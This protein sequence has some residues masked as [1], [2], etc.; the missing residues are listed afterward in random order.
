VLVY[1]YG[2]RRSKIFITLQIIPAKKEKLILYH[3]T[4]KRLFLIL[5]VM[6][7]YV[8][9]H[10]QIAPNKYYVQFTDKNASPYSLE[11]PEAY[12]SQRALDRRA[13]FGIPVD[14]K[15]IPVNPQYLQAV[16]DAGASILNPT[17]WLN[18]VSI[19]TSDPAVISAIEALP[20]VENVMKSPVKLAGTSD[21][22]PFFRAESYSAMAPYAVHSM[23]DGAFYDYGPSLNQIQMIKGDQ[24]HELGY[25]G[26]GL[27]IAVLDAGFS[28]TDNLPVFDSLWDS[29]R[30]LGTR[31]FIDGGPLTFNKHYHG[32]M[33]LSCMGGN[34]PGQ[35]I[36]TAPEAS[37]WLFRTEDGGSE[38]IIEEYNWVTAAEFADSAGADIINSSLGYSTFDDPSQNHT[39]EDMDGNTTP[40][41]I[42]AD[43]AASR[44]MVVVSSAGNSGTSAWYYITAPADGDSVYTI[45]AVNHQGLPASFSSH[46]PTADGRIKPNVAAQ[47]EGTYFAS[48]DGSFIFGN[49]TSFSSPIIAGMMAC[50]W[51]ANPDMNNMEL[52]NAIQASGTLASNPDNKLGYGIPDFMIAHNILTVIDGYEQQA[53]GLITPFPNPFTGSFEVRVETEKPGTAKLTI[54]DISGRMMHESEYLLAS[55]ENQIMVSGLD[56]LKAGIYLLKFELGTVVKTAKVV[57]K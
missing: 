18:G 44:G 37:Y 38:Y 52:L 55:G 28:N 40:I 50:L 42:G 32:T 23:K 57:R 7:A 29:G 46:G 49:G 41:T 51:Q 39:Y 24:L 16:K 4:M 12:L 17:K 15:D 19:Q 27:V 20:F 14:M 53:N 9:L 36:G 47:G 25:R 3:P 5:T 1:S 45:G 43:L 2:F 22:K 10:A 30:I 26:A 6:L 48:P 35:L 11:E 21:E 34:Y 33:V 8:S 56:G 13:A 54:T 31:D